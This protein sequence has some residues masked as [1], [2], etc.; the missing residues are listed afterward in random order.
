MPASNDTPFIYPFIRYQ[1]A[2]KAI[3]F[4]CAAFGFE[5]VTVIPGEGNSVAHA[6]LRLGDG[7]IM[8]G[9]GA[10]PLSRG[11]R[12]ADAGRAEHGLYVFVPDADAHHAQAKAAGADVTREVENTEYGSREYSVLDPEGYHW[13]FGTYH[14]AADGEVA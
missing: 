11:A 5:R 6:T 2:P 7:M 14:P 10:S 8:V 13:S 9:T 3:D 4:L 12:G 1:D